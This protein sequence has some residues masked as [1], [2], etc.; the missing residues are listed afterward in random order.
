MLLW[1]D[2]EADEAVDLGDPFLVYQAL[3]EVH[4][5]D[6]DER[7]SALQEIPDHA[8]QDPD[9]EWLAG[10]AEQARQFLETYEQALGEHTAWVLR[11]LAELA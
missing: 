8:E 5:L 7:W 2:E 6:G 4:K 3:A 10:A 11:K 9:P 1:V